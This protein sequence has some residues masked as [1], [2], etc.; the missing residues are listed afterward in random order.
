MLLQHGPYLFTCGPQI[1]HEPG[2]K[3]QAVASLQCCAVQQRQRATLHSRAEA[4]RDGKGT[5]GMLLQQLCTP[6]DAHAVLCSENSAPNA[7][8]ALYHAHML[9]VSKSSLDVIADSVHL[10]WHNLVHVTLA[11]HSWCCCRSACHALY[12]DVHM[13]VQTLETTSRLRQSLHVT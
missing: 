7:S 1:S 8:S 12:T 3:H 11:F 4:G 13:V 9:V 5:Q 6:V 10:P 2:A